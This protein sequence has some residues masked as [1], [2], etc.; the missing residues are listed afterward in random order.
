MGSFDHLMGAIEALMGDVNR[1]DNLL[2]QYPEDIKAQSEREQSIKSE[3]QDRSAHIA[4]W[5][6]KIG[7]TSETLKE[8]QDK[9]DAAKKE[10]E[11][12]TDKIKQTK[13]LIAKKDS[14]IDQLENEWKDCERKL[15]QNKLPFIK[16]NLADKALKETIKLKESYEEAIYEDLEKYTQEH[17]D[18]LVYDKLNYDKIKLNSKDNYF[19]VYDTDGNPTR[20][21]MNTGHSILLVLSFISALT[22]LAKETWKEE[23]PLVMDAPTSEIG[24]S[25]IESALTGFTKVF[26]QVI[27]ILKD[28]SLPNELSKSLQDKIGKRYWIEMDKN[29]QHSIV[30][31]S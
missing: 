23:Y 21:I 11:K 24:D 14:E 17:W 1:V 27:V 2:N 7:D 28:G 22:R 18:I 30:F 15:D 13:T 31:N 3:M 8:L 6:K 12:T 29:K 19:E 9:Q 20:S 5:K 10:Q 4:G 16:A 26:N 25:A